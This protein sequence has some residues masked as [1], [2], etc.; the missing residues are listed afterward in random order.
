MCCLGVVHTP[1]QSTRHT[2]PPFRV[3]RSSHHNHYTCQLHEAALAAGKST[4]HK[5]A[6]MHTQ[7]DG[8]IDVGQAEDL[9]KAFNWI[10]LPPNF[11]ADLEGLEEMTEEELHE[12]LEKIGSLRPTG[13]L[14]RQFLWNRFSIPPILTAS[15]DMG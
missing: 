3:H 5:H 2:I 10:P 1:V 6:H 13:D 11:N 8:G 15:G 12:E 14:M 7:P 4:C 9:I